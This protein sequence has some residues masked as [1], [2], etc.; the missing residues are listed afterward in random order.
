VGRL[1]VGIAH[2]FNNIL[3]VVLGAASELRDRA[4]EPAARE[5]VDE[6]IEGGDRAAALTRQ[7]LA[8]SRQHPQ[9]L[10]HLDLNVVVRGVARMFRR[11][12][13]ENVV[14]DV[15]LHGAPVAVRADLGQLEQVVLNLVLNARDAMPAGGRVTIRTAIAGRAP[16]ECGVAAERCAVLEVRDEGPGIAAEVRPHVFEPFFT[17]KPDGRG[18]GLGL[19]TVAAIVRQSGG[20]I[21]LDTA[22]RAG[23]TFR[24]Y[25]PRVEG[26]STA[27]AP[28]A[29]QLARGD[30]VV[31]VV[32]DDPAV[33]GFVRRTLD[34]AGYAVLEAPGPEQAL[35]LAAR[36][37]GFDVLLTDVVMPGMSGRELAARLHAR[38]PALPV[39]FVSGYT[40]DASVRS[41]TLPPGQI[42]LEKP[43]TGAA[44]AAAV[45]AVLER[46]DGRGAERCDRPTA[47]TR[48]AS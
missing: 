36:H 16:E 17:T 46:A 10:Q 20:G 24:I 12:I 25:L 9:R 29:A 32:E 7:L 35:A 22:P 28:D 38:R 13:P 30:E 48:S 33:R 40:E 27:P 8:F 43:F 2:D 6:V 21:V 23:A 37:V 15:E 4:A 44:V 42:F 19:A 18:T 3:T 47:L 5:L 26:A 11:L 45:R 14:I 39:V 41:G 1:A 31:L 34:A